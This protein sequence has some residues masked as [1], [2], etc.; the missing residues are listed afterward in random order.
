M[1]LKKYKL[2]KKNRRLISFLASILALFLLAGCAT[3][4]YGRLER[5]RDLNS[6]FLHYE[7]LPDYNYYTTGGYD[8]PNAILLI[9]K[10]YQLENPKNL[11]H[12]IPNVSRGQMKKWIDTIAPEQDYRYSNAYFAAYILAPDGMR[13][14]VWYATEPLAKVKFLG[15]NRIRVYTPELMP[16]PIMKYGVDIE[17]GF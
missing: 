15:E 3:G 10:D 5:N 9:H 17:G 4:N 8:H 2:T 7:V 12:R 16:R 11:W 6:Q 1:S 13:A 14:G